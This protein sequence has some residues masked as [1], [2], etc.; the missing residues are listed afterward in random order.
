[1]IN[2]FTPLSHLHSEFATHWWKSAHS[3]NA[4][5]LNWYLLG[6]KR[7]P[8]NPHK[9]G[10][11]YLLKAIFKIS[12]EYPCPFYMGVQPGLH[13]IR[14]TTDSYQHCCKGHSNHSSIQVSSEWVGHTVVS[15]WASFVPNISTMYRSVSPHALYHTINDIACITYNYNLCLLQKM[16]YPNHWLNNIIYIFRCKNVYQMVTYSEMCTK[17]SFPPSSGVIKPWPLFRQNSLQTPV[18]SGDSDAIRDLTEIKVS[19]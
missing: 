14:S 10:S 6:V 8:S 5:F 4:L 16:L 17:I 2:W 1:M 13:P 11:W 7:G 3:V 18:C 19:K 15:T 12:D 9:T